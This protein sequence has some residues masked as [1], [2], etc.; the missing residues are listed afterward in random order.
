MYLIDTNVISEA[1]KE[2]RANLGVMDFL[3]RAANSGEA[4]YIAT[5][6]LGELRRGVE[7]ERHVVELSVGRL[8]VPAQVRHRTGK[9]VLIEGQER[10]QEGDEDANTA[11][12]HG[13]C[14]PRWRDLEARHLHRRDGSRLRA[15]K[16][17]EN[18]EALAIAIPLLSPE[19]GRKARDALGA[20]EARMKTETIGR[21]LSD[22]NPEIRRAA[23]LACALKEAKQ[24]VPRLIDLLNDPELGVSRAA[25]FALKEMAGQD[26]GPAV[27]ADAAD[28]KHSAAGWQ[29]WWAQQ[30][31]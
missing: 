18:T 2:G 9:N 6:S 7:V 19:M 26:F 14:R 1:R 29:A 22:A 12:L 25:H 13:I 15:Q 27:D 5:V 17:G 4:L 31:H 28:R 16:G 20:R 23:A 30:S 3:R 11:A 8:D 24:F 21:D 10:R